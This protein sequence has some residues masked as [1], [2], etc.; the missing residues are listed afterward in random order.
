M[1]FVCRFS[2]IDNTKETVDCSI[3]SNTSPHDLIGYSTPLPYHPSH[4]PAPSSD[5][6]PSS[7]SKISP[8]D[9]PICTSCA[10]KSTDQSLRDLATHVE[11]GF[12]DSADVVLD[13]FMSVGEALS[14]RG[15]MRKNRREAL[16]Q[17]ME[18]TTF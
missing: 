9:F 8:S 7:A 4:V 18:R 1:T 17:E 14:E 3:C 15:E 10:S 12:G 2:L 5:E 13:D 11:G 6:L 16:K